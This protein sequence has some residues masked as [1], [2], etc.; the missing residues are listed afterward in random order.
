MDDSKRLARVGEESGCLELFSGVA[1][2]SVD[3]FVHRAGGGREIYD[4]GFANCF[5]GS[6]GIEQKSDIAAIARMLTI[7]CR[8]KGY[9]VSTAGFEKD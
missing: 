4:E 7:R 8:A 9:A 3:Q 1:T 6:I 5:G 2:S